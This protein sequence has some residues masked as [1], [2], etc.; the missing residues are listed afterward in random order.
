MK[1]PRPRLMNEAAAAGAD[2]AGGGAV[3]TTAA[4]AGGA[5]GAANALA[6]ANAP[7]P[8][9]E[10]IPEKHRVMKADGTFDIEASFGKVEEHRAALEKRIGAGDSI[11]PKAAAD[12]TFALPKDLEGLWEPA[13]DPKFTAFRDKAHEA[14]LSQSQ[15]EFVVGQYLESASALATGAASLSSEEAIADL[16]KTWAQPAEYDK[17]MSASLM[18]VEHYAGDQAAAQKLVERYGNDPDFVRLMAKVGGDMGEGKTIPRGDAAG[19]SIEELIRSDAYLDP[20][21]KDHAAAAAR[22]QQAYRRKYGDA[23]AT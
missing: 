4:A 20:K 8:L 3:G 9:H 21:H 10:R 22:V 16:R 5:E 12:Y 6:A 14:G 7:K 2:G 18:A 23:P 17:H 1:F 15:F 11:R 19:Q 13:K